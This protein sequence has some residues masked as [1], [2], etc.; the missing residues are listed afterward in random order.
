MNDCD[1]LVVGGGINGAGIARD[2]AGRGLEVCLVERDD[3][4]A[5]TSS[6]STKLI[7]GGLRYLEQYEFR[8]VREALA[9]RER[10]LAIAPHII[11]P[12]R[13]VLP[14]A[15]GMRPR[16]LLRL[17]LFVYD[18]LER[19]ERLAASRELDLR[20]GGHEALDARLTGGFEYSDCWVE[21]S[22]LVVLTA[23]DAAE[24]GA[25]IRTHTRLA[26][27]A[28]R[29]DR[30]LATLT[31][32]SGVTSMLSARAVVN[33]A[34]TWVNDVVAL[35]GLT[36]RVTIRR[37]KGSH[38]IFPRLF[39]GE[40]AYLLQGPDRRVVFMIPFEHDFTLV[41]TTDLP[42]TGDATSVHIDADEAQYLCDCVN[43]Y[44]ALPVRPELAVGSYAGVRSLVDGGEEAAQRVSRDYRLELQQ[45]DA[46]PLLSVYGGK[47]TTH[48]RLAEHALEL[49]M[50]ALGHEPGASWTARQPLP[51]GD[52]A[53]DDVEAFERSL[54][55]RWPALAPQFLRRLARTYGT[56]T[57]RLLGDARTPADLGEDFGL[58]LTQRELD[59]L[60]E[61]EW[62][63]NADDVLRRRTRLGL[64]AP[65][66]M[67][68]SIEDYFSTKARS[69]T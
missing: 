65:A 47:I 28:A 14:Y 64:D 62:A 32:D 18:H 52:L 58:G 63:R 25:Q 53:G 41:G 22:R 17:G 33:A 10:L 66:A 21:D 31:S 56:R 42:F 68:Q 3:L 49:L 45:D 38:L 27:L 9:E 57:E 23:L 19:R 37:V 7:H 24:R 55:S 15:P 40:H 69:I 26:G 1:L 35:A 20:A 36:P 43:R 30:W 5:H 8:L 54:R 11:R 60:R 51:G 48:R 6:A 2:A 12:L 16:W 50:P 46:P 67:R 44:L 34:G 61:V 29:G 13:F 4:A 59:Y 39:E